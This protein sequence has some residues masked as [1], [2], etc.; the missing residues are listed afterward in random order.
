MFPNLFFLDS[1]LQ[2]C[3]GWDLRFAYAEVIQESL[4]DLIAVLASFRW[5]ENLL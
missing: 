2:K 3:L 1:Y 5:N 4:S